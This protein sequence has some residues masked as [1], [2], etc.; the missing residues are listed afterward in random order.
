MILLSVYWGAFQLAQIYS[1]K[2]HKLSLSNGKTFFYIQS[3]LAI[4]LIDRKTLQ[5][6]VMV[7][8]DN[9]M[10]KGNC[11]KVER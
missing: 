3:K 7:Q 6:Y 5:L 9:T 1:W 2:F 11:V 4:S 10:E 8:E